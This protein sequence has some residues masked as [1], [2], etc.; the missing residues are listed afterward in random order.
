[1]IIKRIQ[2]IIMPYGPTVM[3]VLEDESIT[4]NAKE[5]SILL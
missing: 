3:A 1:M 5:Q 4:S 2:S